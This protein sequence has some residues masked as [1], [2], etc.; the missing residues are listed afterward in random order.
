MEANGAEAYLV[1]TGWIGLRNI[2]S[3]IEYLGGIF[4]IDNQLKNGTKIN[5]KLYL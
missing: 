1:N 3:R 2:R 5:I 4:E